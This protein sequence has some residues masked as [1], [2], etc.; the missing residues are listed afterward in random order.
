MMRRVSRS[1][2]II[3][4]AIILCSALGRHLDFR[5]FLLDI[6]NME[7]RVNGIQAHAVQAYRIKLFHAAF[8]PSQRKPSGI[9]SAALFFRNI[10]RQNLS[11]SFA[12]DH[13]I[14][15]VQR[16]GNLYPYLAIVQVGLS[17]YGNRRGRGP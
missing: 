15:P 13:H 8:L 9:Q 1:R 14:H 11:G 7:P 2:R 16:V 3:P 5:G 6:R 10:G 4:K 17:R 12:V